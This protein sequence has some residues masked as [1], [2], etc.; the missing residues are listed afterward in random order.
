[1]ALITEIDLETLFDGEGVP[2][3]ANQEEQAN[4]PR[5]DMTGPT[6]QQDAA[7]HDTSKYVKPFPPESILHKQTV[8]IAKSGSDTQYM[9]QASGKEMQDTPGYPKGTPLDNGGDAISTYSAGV[10]RKD[11]PERGREQEVVRFVQVAHRKRTT[12]RNYFAMTWEERKDS[13]CQRVC[14]GDTDGKRDDVH[15]RAVRSEH[16]RGKGASPRHGSMGTRFAMGRSNGKNQSSRRRRDEEDDP[17]RK[18]HGSPQLS[19]RTSC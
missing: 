11:S 5:E 6:V 4:P 16:A 17:R 19:L 12:R 13:C 10:R 1:M 15:A 9:G 3:T 2:E 14:S 8:A 7:D 18:G